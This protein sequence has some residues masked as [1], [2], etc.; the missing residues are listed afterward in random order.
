MHT[1]NEAEGGDDQVTNTNMEE[2]LEGSTSLSV[3]A[4]LLKNNVLVQVDTVES[5]RMNISFV[6]NDRRENG[7]NARN[8]KEEPTS[9]GTNQMLKMSPLREVL[10]KLLEMAGCGT[11]GFF[12]RSSGSSGLILGLVRTTLFSSLFLLQ[13]INGFLVISIALGIFVTFR[14]S[15]SQTLVKGSESGN[16]GKSDNDTP[17]YESWFRLAYD[18]RCKKGQ[19]VPPSSL[20]DSPLSRE[21]L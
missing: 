13:S 18:K 1:R 4:N 12:R 20:L 3:K 19:H 17:N 2:S 9:G 11:N 16:E 8:I 15:E 14:F 6:N 21:P 10:G 5:K 7:L